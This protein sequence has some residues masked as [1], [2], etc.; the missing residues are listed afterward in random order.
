MGTRVIRAAKKSWVA[1]PDITISECI[2]ESNICK[3]SILAKKQP[4]STH[5]VHC[6]H[7]PSCPHCQGGS[8]CADAASARGQK[9]WTTGWRYSH[10]HGPWSWTCCWVDMV[11][12]SSAGRLCLGKERVCAICALSAQEPWCYRGT[13]KVKAAYT[14]EKQGLPVVVTSFCIWFSVHIPDFSPHQVSSAPA[15]CIMKTDLHIQTNDPRR[16]NSG[17]QNITHAHPF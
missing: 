12:A 9:G 14:N 8:S 7:D 4:H 5:L 11:P 17:W 6:L 15:S 2:K 10:S 13:I 1:S 16:G 3:P